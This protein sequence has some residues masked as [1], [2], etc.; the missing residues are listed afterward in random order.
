ML[1]ENWYWLPALLKRLSRHCDTGSIIPDDLANNLARTKYFHRVLDP[2]QVALATFDMVVHTPATQ[3]EV[4]GM[5]ATE[6]Y[7]RILCEITGLE[8]PKTIAGAE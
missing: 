1:L 2:L 3:E 6:I 5:N 7:N 8:G 4:D